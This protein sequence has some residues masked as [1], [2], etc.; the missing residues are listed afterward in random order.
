MCTSCFL[1]LPLVCFLASIQV[2]A[3]VGT[4]A[5]EALCSEFKRKPAVSKLS[6]VSSTSIEPQGRRLVVRRLA[7]EAD[8][9]EPQR[10]WP[11]HTSLQTQQL[12][13]QSACVFVKAKQPLRQWFNS[14]MAEAERSAQLAGICRSARRSLPFPGRVGI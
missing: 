2:F 13:R 11:S 1:A 5:A 7:R 4:N 3:R 8:S 6:V 9:G 12:L 10:C 14:G